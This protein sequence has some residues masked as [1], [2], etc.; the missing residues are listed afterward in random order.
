VVVV[1]VV[2]MTKQVQPN[3]YIFIVV[4]NQSIL[5]G[6]DHKKICRI[7]AREAA[8]ARLAYDLLQNMIHYSHRLAIHFICLSSLLP[9]L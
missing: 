7:S 3:G 9:E 2:I 4:T 6:N 1:V 8:S 5:W